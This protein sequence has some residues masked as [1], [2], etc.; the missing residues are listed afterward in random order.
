MAV[1][2][3]LNVRR[4]KGDRGVFAVEEINKGA[5]ILDFPGRAV[6][7]RKSG[8]WDLQ[9]GKNSFIRAF[10]KSQIDNFLNHSCRPNAFIK[11]KGKEFY[12]IAM[13]RIKTGEEITFD[14]DTTDY[15]NWEFRFFCRCKSRICRKTVRGFKY[16]SQPQK[17][18]LERHLV[19]YLKRIFE[20]ELTENSSLK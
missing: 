9:T 8:P 1:F 16:L 3:K 5:V 17:K 18:K 13:R 15:D 14:Y 20:K 6:P 10:S 19:P 11:Q 2:A 7:E 12:L 4:S